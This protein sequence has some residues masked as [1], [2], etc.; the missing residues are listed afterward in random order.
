MALPIP[1]IRK[2]LDLRSDT[3]TMPTLEM[4]EAM[5]NAVLGD[6]GR[7]DLTGR[8]EDPTVFELE[9]LAAAILGK[10]DAVYV[11]TGTLA[12]HMAMFTAADRGDK[13]LIEKMA[14]I[15]IN[16]K[17]VFLPR[18]GGLIPVFY[19]LTKDCQID[20]G[21]IERLLA[22]DDI[23]VLCLENTH[24]H[25]GGACLTLETT[26]AVCERAQAKG[27]HVHLDGA[28]IFN[29]AVALGVD[30]KE[31]VAPVDS[32]MFC[33]SKGL[34]APVGSLLAGSAEFIA[35]A[36]SVGKMLGVFMRQSG[37][38]AAAGITALKQ[39]IARL[40]EDHENA[41]LL[42]RLLRG[43][44]NVIMEPTANQTN[45]VYLKV[46]PTGLTAQQVVDGLREKG[47]LAAKMTDESIRFAMHKD[48]SQADVEKA[49]AIVIAYFASLKK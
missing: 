44:D 36:R 3:A 15:Y 38:I 29:A 5:R 8:G 2:M 25:S 39:N 7:M 23:K 28:R 40:K 16:E 27:A 1:E 10:E 19:H 33:V 13:V 20:I 35:R 26:R 45:F 47:L 32:L 22:D 34:C 17:F 9:I 31:L 41:A 37:V 30:V 48:L 18:Y 43:I 11:P 49:S 46:T 42:G 24:N 14:H 6:G 4:R 12:N 21:E